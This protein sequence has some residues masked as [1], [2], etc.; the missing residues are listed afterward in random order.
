MTGDLVVTPVGDP[1]HRLVF[2]H[3]LFGRG[4]NWTAVA[5]RLLPAGSLLVDLPNH[6]ASPWTT[7]FSYEDM[8]DAVAALLSGLDRPSLVGHSMGGRVAM[9]TALRHPDA[10][11][12]LVVEDTAP[13]DLDMTEFAGLA[14][15]MAALPLAEITNRGQAAQ[16]LG[17]RIHDQRV[18]GFLLQ[19]LT[20]TPGGYR[21]QLNLAVLARDMDRIGAWPATTGTFPRPVLW[22]TGDESTRTTAAHQA[23]MT[24]LF[25]L[26]RRINIRGAGHWVHAD[27]PDLFAQ[28][29]QRFVT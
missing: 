1:P 23:A 24:A 7:H 14:A 5:K 17:A 8:A 29:L 22:I 19:N 10:L 28:A 16:W 27:A 6:G 25:P 2:L 13:A 20:A 21:W 18:L 3:G 12:R 11:D 9:L 26:T 15:A 4:R